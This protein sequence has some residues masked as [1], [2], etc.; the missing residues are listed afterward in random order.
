MKMVKMARRWPLLA[1]PR[2]AAPPPTTAL[3][4]VFWND[5]FHPFSQKK[6]L[7][8]RHYTSFISVT[9]LPGIQ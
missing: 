7:R 3:A 4:T 5:R 2:W 9:S 6:S 8:S 1:R